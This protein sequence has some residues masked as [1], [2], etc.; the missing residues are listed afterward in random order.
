MPSRKGVK[1]PSRLPLIIPD[2]KHY[3][4]F[5]VSRVGKQPLAGRVRRSRCVGNNYQRL[6][7]GD[8]GFGRFFGQRQH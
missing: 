8:V 1:I 3:L 7:V 4:E 2:N 6:K 5:P